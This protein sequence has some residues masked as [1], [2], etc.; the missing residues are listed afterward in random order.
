MFWKKKK[1]SSMNNLMKKV[2][3]EDQLKFQ[4]EVRQDNIR[5]M[6]GVGR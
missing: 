1:W 3:F 6:K 2:N 4:Q 5:L